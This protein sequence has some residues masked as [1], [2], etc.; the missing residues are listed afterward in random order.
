MRTQLN[1]MSDVKI[2]VNDMVIKCSSLA[3]VKVPTANST[4]LDGSH[5]IFDYVDMSVA[6]QTE[7]GLLTPIVKNAHT[8]R[9]GEIAREMK[10]LADKAKAGKLKPEEFQGGTFTI[11]NLGM[12]GVKEFSAIINPPQVGDR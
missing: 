4:W 3:C 9:L 12:F 7:K 1:T 6:V 10:E 8:K 11:S 2:S 5:R